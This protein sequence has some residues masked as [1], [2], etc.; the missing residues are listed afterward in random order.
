MHEVGVWGLLSPAVT[1][2]LAI[3]TRQVILSLVVGCVAGF[4]VLSNFHVGHGLQSAVQGVVDVFKSD[5]VVR[6]LIFTVM[7][8]GVIHLARLTGGMKGLVNQ[9]SGRLRIVKGPI[10]IQLLAGALASVVFIDSYLAMLTSGAATSELVRRHGVAREQVAYVLKNVGISAWSSAIFN[11][12]GAMMLGIIAVQVENGSIQGNPFNILAHSIVYNLFAWASIAMVLVSIFTRFSFPGMRRAKQRAATGTELREGAVPLTA[13]GEE[14]QISS[15][16]VSNL[17]V[18]L[19]SIFL[20]VPVGLY[21]TGGGEIGNGSASTAILWAVLFGQ[22][23]GF[24]H[25]VLIKRV[26]NIETYFNRLVEGYQAMLPLV[27]VLTLAFLIGDLSSQLQI[28]QFL[29]QHFSVLMPVSLVAA[30]VFLVAALISLSTGTSWGTFSIM[31]PIGI[32]LAVSSGADPYLVIGAAISG[33]I[34]GDT[35]SPIS[36]TGIVTATATGNNLM[37]HIKTQLP[38]C[39]TAAGIAL[40]GFVILGL[41]KSL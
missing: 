20:F 9:I 23:V 32:Q 26:M 3:F 13:L 12:W 38:Y 33:A 41:T 16:S 1:I 30:F 36:D 4:M 34:F 24:V 11:G 7:I 19:L 17:L 6:T 29:A 2:C 28:G 31:I 39:L 22:C 37:D 35:T 18:P 21:I 8:S 25:Y 14:E 40:V 10:S 5:G 27:V 15:A